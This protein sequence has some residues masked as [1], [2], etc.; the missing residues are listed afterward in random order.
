[1]ELIRGLCELRLRLQERLLEAAGCLDAVFALLINLAHEGSLFSVLSFPLCELLETAA[2][3]K[4]E[5]S[6]SL[7]DTD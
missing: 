4:N 3:C 7:E 5:Q 6:D 2:G 1:M